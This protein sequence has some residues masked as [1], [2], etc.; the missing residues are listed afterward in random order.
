M[1]PGAWRDGGPHTEH[2][3]EAGGG[4]RQVPHPCFYEP[5]LALLPPHCAREATGYLLTA[6]IPAPGPASSRPQSQTKHHRL[7]LR[8]PGCLSV[9]WSHLPRA[10][11][12]RGPCW[13]FPTARKAASSPLLPSF[14][15]EEQN[16]EGTRAEMFCLLPRQSLH[17]SWST[18]ATWTLTWPVA[19]G[20]APGAFGDSAENSHVSLAALSA[21]GKGPPVPGRALRPRPAHL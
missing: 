10:R 8:S 9:L 18:W 16:E 5:D 19:E 13:A 4:G 7:S 11:G 14:A 6:A 3:G 20:M 15:V 17:P 1:S 12:L 2:S 21:V